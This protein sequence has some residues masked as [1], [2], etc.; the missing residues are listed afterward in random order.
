ML[1]KLF[2]NLSAKFRNENALSDITWVMCETSE[3]FRKLF[4]KFFFPNDE[5]NNILEFRR[6]YSLADSRPDFFIKNGSD[7]FLIEVKIYD[8]KHHF[9][10]YTDAFNIPKSHLGYITNYNLWQNGY[11][12][13]TWKVFYEYLDIKKENLTK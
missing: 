12:V 8:T 6:E 13:K 11:S 3:T 1:T 4:L 7:I 2:D 9:D 5:F 10:Q